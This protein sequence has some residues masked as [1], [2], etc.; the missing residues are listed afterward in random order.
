MGGKGYWP[1]HE[2]KLIRKGRDLKEVPELHRHTKKMDGGIYG[3][4]REKRWEASCGDT[5][6]T[7]EGQLWRETRDHKKAYRKKPQARKMLH[8]IQPNRRGSGNKRKG[9]KKRR[10]QADPQIKRISGWNHS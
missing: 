3:G 4:K 6:A 7:A 2:K 1:I 9:P 8:V 5:F 10:C